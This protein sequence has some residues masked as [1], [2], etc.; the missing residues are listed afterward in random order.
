MGDGCACVVYVEGGIS[1]GALK[2][3]RGREGCGG[4]DKMWDNAFWA[5][6]LGSSMHGDGGC[7]KSA[8][9]GKIPKVDW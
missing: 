6:V 4:G 2:R 5:A 9:V 1:D 8:L 3:G 7:G